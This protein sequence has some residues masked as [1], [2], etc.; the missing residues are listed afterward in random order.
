M[1]IE[2]TGSLGR[3][4]IDG[5]HWM[6]L[7]LIA[8]GGELTRIQP[9]FVLN[10]GSAFDFGL[11]VAGKSPDIIDDVVAK[12]GSPLPI[13]DD[14]SE[15]APS[16]TALNLNE[17][18]TLQWMKVPAASRDEVKSGYTSNSHFDEVQR[19]ANLARAAF[20]DGKPSPTEIASLHDA[21]DIAGVPEGPD[22]TFT[23]GL[24]QHVVAMRREV[25]ERQIA[26]NDFVEVVQTG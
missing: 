21:M 4:G 2:A 19:R 8:D 14:R 12:P 15:V 16:V 9:P 6:P 1:T 7:T 3:L 25:F 24:L 13:D 18:G 5:D 11:G 20:G 23:I 26:I 17:D 10:E 22:D